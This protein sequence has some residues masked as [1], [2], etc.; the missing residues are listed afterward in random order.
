[1]THILNINDMVIAQL[2]SQAI[3]ER[4][5]EGSDWRKSDDPLYLYPNKQLQSMAMKGKDEKETNT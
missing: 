3:I 1:M 4:A 2:W 5:L